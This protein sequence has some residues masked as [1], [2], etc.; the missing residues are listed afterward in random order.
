MRCA[1]ERA[2]PSSEAAAV[3]LTAPRSATTVNSRSARPTDSI[4]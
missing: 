3:T 2:T 1:V 4:G